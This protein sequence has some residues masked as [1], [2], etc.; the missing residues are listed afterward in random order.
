MSFH[1]E[2]TQGIDLGR[3]RLSKFLNPLPSNPT[4]PARQS[5]L[6][7]EDPTAERFLSSISQQPTASPSRFRL[8]QLVGQLWPVNVTT[9]PKALQV[10][11]EGGR[12]SQKLGI[13]NPWD[14]RIGVSAELQSGPDVRVSASDVLSHEL[15]HALDV[16]G[17]DLVPIKDLIAIN[18]R[19][20]DFFDPKKGTSPAYDKER[21]AHFLSRNFLS[22]FSPA[23]RSYYA[24]REKLLRKA[25][26]EELFRRSR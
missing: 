25:A 10:V 7:G 11:D 9:N 19:R 15:G 26:I 12:F 1:S 14:K 23:E 17:T 2:L 21:F 4:I 20:E 8:S 3:E 5:G 24:E 6:H 13:F 16:L 22:Q 18:K